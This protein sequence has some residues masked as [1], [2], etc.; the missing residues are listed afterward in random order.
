[1]IDPRRKPQITQ[2]L[3]YRVADRMAVSR[4]FIGK[5]AHARNIAHSRFPVSYHVINLICRGTQYA[6]SRISSLYTCTRA[7]C[8]AIRNTVMQT[9][10][11]LKHREREREQSSFHTRELERNGSVRM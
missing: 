8:V 1:M 7:M 6:V 10:N 5:L 3:V 9:E 11:I 4:S 2:Q